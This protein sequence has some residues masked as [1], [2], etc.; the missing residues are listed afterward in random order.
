MKTFCVQQ[1]VHNL[2]TPQLQAC[3][4]YIGGKLDELSM[5]GRGENEGIPAHF[6]SKSATVVHPFPG[7]EFL[8]V[9]L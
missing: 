9:S 2:I 4:T 8:V 5:C 7:S 6:T 3:I 1:A